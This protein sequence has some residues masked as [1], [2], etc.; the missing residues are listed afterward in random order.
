MALVQQDDPVAVFDHAAHIVG[1]HQ[2]GG[3]VLPDLL[4]PPVAL[5]LEKYVSHGK[6]LVHDQDLR[7]DVDRHRKGQPYE[8]TAGIGLDGLVHEVSD[9]CKFQ[10]VR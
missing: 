1:H 3:A 4:H 9:I 10:D 2:D 8:H 5:R 6:R 7:L